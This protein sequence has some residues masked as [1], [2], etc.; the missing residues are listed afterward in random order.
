MKNYT[1]LSFILLFCCS[2]FTSN[3]QKRTPSYENAAIVH[4]FDGS[5]FIG[6]IV[7]EN[8]DQIILEI[9]T[10]NEIRV[11]KRKIKRIYRNAENT[12][13]Y[14][15][16]R[17]HDIKGLFIGLDFGFSVAADEGSVHLDFLMG[18]RLNERFLVGA[19]LGFYGN[20]TTL[21][22]N[23]WTS[24]QFLTLYGYG[25]YYL[26]NRR[27]RPFT[28]TKLGYGIG[29]DVDFGNEH[30]GGIHFQPGLGLHFASKKRS[31]LTIMLSQYVQYTQGN[32]VSQDFFSNPI[33]FDYSI[34]YNRTMLTIGLDF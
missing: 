3:A 20:T 32:N 8:A 12:F 14:S 10:G 33:V 6:R 29:G 1:L 4:Y 18:T 11:N 15:K 13:V 9:T 21:A 34:W 16:G 5:V 23:F 26:G 27:V 25:R 2:T 24:H 17:M 22:D 31:T 28:F 19:G 30:S 7:D